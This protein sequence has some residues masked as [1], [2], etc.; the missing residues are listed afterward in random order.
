MVQLFKESVWLWQ[1]LVAL[2]KQTT[3]ADRERVNGVKSRAFRRVIRR[4][5][6][7]RR[8]DPDIC[9]EVV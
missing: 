4:E 6:K 9:L 5:A 2:A 7:A 1:R 8:I 3:G